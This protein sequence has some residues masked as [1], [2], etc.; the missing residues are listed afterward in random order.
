LAEAAGGTVLWGG[1]YDASDPLALE[2]Q[3]DVAGNIARTL[4]PHLNNLELHRTRGKRPEDLDAY[5]LM[6]QAREL[7]FALEQSAFDQAGDLLQTALRLDP[8]YAPL[9][10]AAADWRSLRIGQGWSPDPESDVRAL[11]NL[12]RSAIALDAGSGRALAMLAHNRTILHR[13]YDDALKLLERA[14]D[15]TPNDAEA[16]MWSTP[17]YAYIGEPAE[18]LRR[19]ERAITLSPEDPFMFRYEHFRCIAHYAAGDYAEAANWGVRSLRRNPH[20][21]SNLR[22]AAAALVGLGRAAEAR[23]LTEKVMEL[24]PG[25]R[26]APMISRQAFRDEAQRE[27]Y[28]KHLVEAGLPA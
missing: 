4:V 10:A 1:V 14:V 8:G 12:A 27:Q 13:Q 9:Y 3:D 22:M 2:T 20:Y 21:T 15:A 6:L 16:L 18:A 17:T 19:I 23:P 26:V 28:G 25:F 7:V 11:E 5:H 24:Q